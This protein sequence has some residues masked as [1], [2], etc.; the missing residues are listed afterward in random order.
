MKFSGLVISDARLTS[1][2]RFGA[3]AGDVAL[4]FATTHSMWLWLRQ[5]TWGKEKPK[6]PGYTLLY[7]EAIYW[8]LFHETTLSAFIT[9]RLIR[10]TKPPNEVSELCSRFTLKQRTNVLKIVSRS[11]THKVKCCEIYT[12]LIWVKVR[13][14]KS[15]Q[16]CL[17]FFSLRPRTESISRLPTSEIS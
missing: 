7:F 5:R 12:L 10:F 1:P 15:D 4:G 8:R 17:P 2:P 6:S 3:F 14:M 11:S 9:L 13:S 16:G